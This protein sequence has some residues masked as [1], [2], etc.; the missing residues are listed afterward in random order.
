MP[1][2]SPN[3]E[4]MEVACVMR[5]IEQ[6]ERTTFIGGNAARGGKI[7]CTEAWLMLT[8]FPCLRQ[9]GGFLAKPGRKEL[10]PGSMFFRGN[11]ILVKRK[12]D[13]GEPFLYNLKLRR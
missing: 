13:K 6:T 8:A 11:F 9:R 3:L 5:G 10:R 4:P 2:E 7:A 1:S 12:V